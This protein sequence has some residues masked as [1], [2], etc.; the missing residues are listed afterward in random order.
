[1][2]HL[3]A[4]AVALVFLIA[5]ATAADKGCANPQSVAKVDGMVCD[6]CAQGLKKVLLKEANV[7]SVD[8]NL[9]TKEVVVTP[10]AGQTIEDATIKAKVD[11][12]GYKFTG[13]EHTC[14]KSAP[15]AANNAGND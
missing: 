12:A 7:E 11:W 5:P 10:K 2:K 4:T 13:I 9:T 1:M 15:K 6:F 14:G 8:I 3:F